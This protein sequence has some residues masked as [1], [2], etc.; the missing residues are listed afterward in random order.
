MEKFIGDTM[1]PCD[2]KVNAI[3]FGCVR[4]EGSTFA[5]VMMFQCLVITI[6]ALVM[7][8]NIPTDECFG[9]PTCQ[10]V[11]PCSTAVP[12]LLRRT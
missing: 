2:W 9:I 11:L 5:E 10:R 6:Q 1:V 8:K 12:S 4:G 7:N 3:G